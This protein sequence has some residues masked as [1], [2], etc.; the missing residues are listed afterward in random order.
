MGRLCRR[1]EAD[2]LLE[3]I[4]MHGLIGQPAEK[5]PP[6]L[7]RVSMASPSDPTPLYERGANGVVSAH[8][9]RLLAHLRFLEVGH[10]L[11]GEKLYRAHDLLVGQPGEPEC[12]EDMVDSGS[13]G[14]LQPLHHHLGGAPQWG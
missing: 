4:N 2:R 10:N 12:A 8:R 7:S 6:T 14:F 9:V 13:L 1:G 5:F 3:N 11:G